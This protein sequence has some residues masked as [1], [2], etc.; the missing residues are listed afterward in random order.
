MV[1]GPQ[2]AGGPDGG[3]KYVCTIIHYTRDLNKHTIST[4][5]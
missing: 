1:V 5:K 4:V 2:M 3:G